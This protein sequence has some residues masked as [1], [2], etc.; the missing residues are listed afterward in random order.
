VNLLMRSLQPQPDPGAPIISSGAL[1]A[2]IASVPFYCLLRRLALRACP[3]VRGVLWR[4]ARLRHCRLHAARHEGERPYSFVLSMAQLAAAPPSESALPASVAAPLVAGAGIITRPAQCLTL[5]A[6]VLFALS[7]FR[8]LVI[9]EGRPQNDAPRLLAFLASIRLRD[10]VEPWAFLSGVQFGVPVFNPVDLTLIL[11][12]FASP[13][14][15]PA[16]PPPPPRAG[17]TPALA[18]GYGRR[19]ARRALRAQ[20]A[21]GPMSVPR[22][23]STRDLRLHHRWRRLGIGTLAVPPRRPRTPPPRSLPRTDESLGHP[24]LPWSY[25][26]SVGLTMPG[27][28]PAHQVA[29]QLLD[30]AGGRRRL[31]AAS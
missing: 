3:P 13:A 25:S 9:E 10:R 21:V 27:Y 4:S 31:L 6:P 24:R 7:V 5:H 14:L 26:P 8:R 18:Y 20:P 29:P 1:L 30:T 2:G 15:P 16:P 22:R 23:S 19:S 12:A 11:S 28:I 17:G